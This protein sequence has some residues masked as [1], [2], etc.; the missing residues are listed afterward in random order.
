MSAAKVLDQIPKPA[1]QA[2]PA[3]DDEPAREHWLVRASRALGRTVAALFLPDRALP[4]SVSE[5]RYGT[6]MLLATL[7]AVAFA[8]AVSL[9]VDPS[10]GP[11]MGGPEGGGDGPMS[12]REIADAIEKQRAM[13]QVTLGLG[14]VLGTPAQLF[15]LGLG[16]FLLGRY[17]GGKPTLGSSVAVAAHAALPGAVK[18]LIGAGAALGAKRL[19]P[20]EIPQLVALPLPLDGA[21]ARLFMGVDWFTLYAL[22]MTIIGFR[23][24]AKV[25]RAKAILTIVITFLLYLVVTRL[26]S[27]GGP[28]HGPPHGAR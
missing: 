1:A 13:T 26:L 25:G 20:M 12:D 21:L 8:A 2:R 10:L 3:E 5:G 15:L 6:A 23:A 11:V 22:V 9:R 18:A 7:C 28:P 27:G 19:A 16:L 17:V 14:A 4:A 24:S